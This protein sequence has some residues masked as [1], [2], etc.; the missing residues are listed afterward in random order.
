MREAFSLLTQKTDEKKNIK[1]LVN[2]ARKVK[3]L[4]NNKT[5]KK[6]VMKTREM[7]SGGEKLEAQCGGGLAFFLCS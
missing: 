4:N 1:K 7:Q 2:L 5:H 6:K 3:K